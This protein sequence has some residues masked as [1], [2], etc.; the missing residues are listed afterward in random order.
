MS[1]LKCYEILKYTVHLGFY[2][3]L[4]CL[5]FLCA[6]GLRVLLAQL[7]SNEPGVTQHLWIKGS[8]VN[9]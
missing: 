8:Y 9:L 1:R 2:L 7:V 5:F 4:F 6:N 3:G